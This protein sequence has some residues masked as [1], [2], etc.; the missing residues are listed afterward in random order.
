MCF[1]IAAIDG[2]IVLPRRTRS[3]E[4]VV[5]P[6]GIAIIFIL[7][8]L[9]DHPRT[10]GILG[11]VVA[12]YPQFVVVFVVKVCIV[13][14]LIGREKLINDGCRIVSSCFKI[15]LSRKFSKAKHA[16]IADMCLAVASVFGGN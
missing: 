1:V 4:K 3:I 6:V 14:S 2:N 16:V 11:A 8:V 5:E 13:L 12:P 10:L 15:V 9:H 7:I